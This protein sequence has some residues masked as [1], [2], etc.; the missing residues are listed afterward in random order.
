MGPRI[1][2][3]T[4]GSA[5]AERAV[6]VAAGLARAAGAAVDVLCVA[7]VDPIETAENRDAEHALAVAGQAASA[8]ALAVR[9]LGV[10]AEPAAVVDR[11]VEGILR[12]A[13]ARGDRLLVMSTHGRCGLGRWLHGSGAEAVVRRSPVPVVLV[14]AWKDGA[15]LQLPDG[16]TTIVVPLDGSARAESALAPARWLAALCG[17]SLVLVQAV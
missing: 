2:V 3:T 11:P 12:F 16:P 15:S 4:D 7:D 10:G 6:P 9:R 8:V 14:R 17:G 1:L 13:S 5:L